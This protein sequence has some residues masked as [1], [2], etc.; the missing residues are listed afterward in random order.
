MASAEIALSIKNVGVGFT[1]AD[2]GKVTALDRFSLEVAKGEFVCVLGRSGHGKTTLLNVVAGLQSAHSGEIAVVGKRVTGP[3]IDRGVIFQRDAVFPWMKVEDNVAFGLRVRGIG[4]AERLRIAREQ[5]G[6]VSLSHVARAWPR[7]LSG[8]MRARVAIAAVFAN[9]P[10]ILLAD[11]PFGA[12]DY[13][14]RRQLQSVLLDMWRRTG[15]TVLFVTHDVDEALMLG[16]RVVV[17]A[18]GSIAEDCAIDLPFPRQ[19]D[20][21]ASPHA[22]QLKHLLLHHMG[23]E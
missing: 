17:V 14:T 15:K 3:G 18:D 22:L 4:K 2:G 23:L 1:R 11:E 16:T 20:D 5:L 9:D 8:G 6:L 12:L 21:L 10:P 13:V 7:E 19:D